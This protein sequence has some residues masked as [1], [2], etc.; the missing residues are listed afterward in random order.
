[1][2]IAPR[3]GIDSVATAR[4]PELRVV[5]LRTTRA[6]RKAPAGVTPDGP[7]A[8]RSWTSFDAC[9][10]DYDRYRRRELV[11]AA[12]EVTIQMPWGSLLR[13][14][15]AADETIV[16]GIAGLVRP[17]RLVTVLV[18]VEERDRRLG[19]EP[20]S[21]ADLKRLAPAYA[22]FGLDLVE[23]RPA[24]DDEPRASHSTWATAICLRPTI[25]TQAQSWR[26]KPVL[27]CCSD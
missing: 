1:M 22:R 17:G 7:A 9:A 19:L 26:I 15:L 24:T 27:R 6:G 3:A 16:G 18:S 2:P 20:L 12:D 4:R 14:M 5:P 13:G 25:M 10:A 8:Q 21:T 23:V 11:S